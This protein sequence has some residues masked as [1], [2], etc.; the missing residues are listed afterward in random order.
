MCIRDRVFYPQTV[1]YPAYATP[2]YY[3]PAYF[4]GRRFGA[5]YYNMGPSAAY[6]SRVSGRNQTII[7]QTIIQNSTNIARIHNVVPPR[8]VIVRHAYIRQII[9]PALAQ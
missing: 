3:P 5:G 7:N 1:Y 4:G 9:T 8:G 6:L 2:T